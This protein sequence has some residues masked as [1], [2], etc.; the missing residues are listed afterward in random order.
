M[1]NRPLSTLF[2]LSAVAMMSAC[3]TTPTASPPI[4]YEPA[5]A[6]Q[7][8]AFLAIRDFQI[9]TAPTLE[10]DI[11]TIIHV[12]ERFHAQIDQDPALDWRYVLF[13]DGLD[14][15]VFGKP[16]KEIEQN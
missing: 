10:G 13:P 9:R 11:L 12:G 6:A 1:S 3:A 15:Y 4:T 14:G 7:F 2:A 8:N 16:F 5:T